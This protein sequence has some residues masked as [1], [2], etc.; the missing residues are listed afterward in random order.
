MSWARLALRTHR[1]NHLRGNAVRGR[2]GWA[3][4]IHGYGWSSAADSGPGLDASTIL[5]GPGQCRLLRRPPGRWVPA[6]RSGKAGL[7]SKRSR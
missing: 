4:G 5:P 2:K 1:E 7:D 6:K 3:A